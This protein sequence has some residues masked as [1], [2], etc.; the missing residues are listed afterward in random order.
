MPRLD[1]TN[2]LVQKEQRVPTVFQTSEFVTDLRMDAL[3][4]GNRLVSK[5]HVFAIFLRMG[6][7]LQTV[8]RR[9]S[10]RQIAISSKPSTGN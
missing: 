8:L 9:L 5:L 6:R 10:E 3:F 7:S 1:S 4:A 2:S